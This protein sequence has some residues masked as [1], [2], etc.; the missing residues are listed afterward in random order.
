MSSS[1]PASLRIGA[2]AAGGASSGGV[3]SGWGSAAEAD[4]TSDLVF[5]GLAEG[6]SPADLSPADLSPA[7]LATRV[8]ALLSVNERADADDAGGASL[9]SSRL[10]MKGFAAA[11]MTFEGAGAGEPSRSVAINMV[12]SLPSSGARPTYSTRTRASPLL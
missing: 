4:R 3:T 9:P 2:K 6:V 7:D 12:S 8:D 5:A 11:I 10:E 1:V